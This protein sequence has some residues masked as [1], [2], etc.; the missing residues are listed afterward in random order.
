METVVDV[1]FLPQPIE[2]ELCVI[3]DVLRATTSITTALHN[4]AHC[5]Y[6]VESKEEA[7]KIKEDHPDYILAGEEDGLKISGFDLGNSPFEFSEKAVKDKNIILKTSNGT[8]AAKM[9]RCSEVLAA[10][11]L[12]LSAV[13]ARIK[14][15]RKANIVCSGTLGKISLEDCLLAG[16]IAKNLKYGNAQARIVSGYAEGINDIYK[17]LL[18]STHAQKLI[19]LGFEKDIKFASQIDI[20]NTVPIMKNGN[21]FSTGIIDI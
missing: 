18:K 14:R 2:G 15:R 12:N 11:F 4:G 17:E 9:V 16:F 5:V 7:F 20:T 19:K 1:Y 6:P 8:V 3:I 10:S 13:L 21:C